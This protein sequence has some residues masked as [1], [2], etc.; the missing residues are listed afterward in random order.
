MTVQILRINTIGSVFY[1]VTYELYRFGIFYVVLMDTNY[2]ICIGSVFYVV[3]KDTK[4]NEK[5]TEHPN[6]N[7]NQIE[8]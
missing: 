4:I 3:L 5:K 1:V 2:L 6:I 7:M 8:S